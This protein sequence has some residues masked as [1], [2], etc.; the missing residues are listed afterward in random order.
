MRFSFSDSSRADGIELMSNSFKHLACN[1]EASATDDSVSP[2]A[3]S[4]GGLA[5]SNLQELK[6]CCV[7]GLAGSS[8]LHFAEDGLLLVDMIELF[9]TGDIISI[10]EDGQVD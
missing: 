8:L 6:A 2:F 10:E 1:E 7:E 3:T 5:R 4:N 9:L